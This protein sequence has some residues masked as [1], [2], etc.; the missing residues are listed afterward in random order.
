MA[1]NCDKNDNDEITPGIIGKWKLIEVYSDPGNGSGDF[2]SVESSKTIS[3]TASNKVTSNGNLCNISI[4]TDQ[5]TTGTFS[6]LDS[7]ISPIECTFFDDF[8]VNF[9]IIDSELILY[10]PCFEGCAEKYEK[11]SN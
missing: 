5:T 4:T 10:Y 3:F 7:T 2:N 8:R 11:I 1:F 9:T 6:L